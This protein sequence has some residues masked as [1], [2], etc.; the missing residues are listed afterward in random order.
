VIK[1]GGGLVRDCCRARSASG[2]PRG[3]WPEVR[4]YTTGRMRSIVEGAGLKIRPPDVS[5]RNPVP[6]MLAVSSRSR[7]GRLGVGC[8]RGRVFRLARIRGLGDACARRRR[9]MRR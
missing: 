8:S 2:R 3:T 6:A 1:P 9:S 7:A 5:L 4:R